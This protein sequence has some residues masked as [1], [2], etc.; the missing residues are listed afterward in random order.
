[1]YTRSKTM[2]REQEHKLTIALQELKTSRELCQ[3]LLQEQEDSEVEV[4]MVVDRNSQLKEQLSELDIQYM[5]VIDQRDRL[6]GIIDTFHECT[7]THE[8][9]LDRIT[10]LESELL[11]SQSLV[12]K[13]KLDMESIQVQ[14]NYNLY[15]ELLCVNSPIVNSMLPSVTPNQISTIDLTCEDSFNNSVSVS[16]TNTSSYRVKPFKSSVLSKK[17]LKKCRKLDKSIKKTQNALKLQKNN[18]NKVL[19]K[20]DHSQLIEELELCTNKLKQSQIMYDTDTQQLYADISR[21]EK[22]LF[23]ANAKYQLVQKENSEHILAA[24]ELVDLCTYNAERYDSLINNHSCDCVC[25]SLKS[26]PESSSSLNSKT[27]NQSTPTKKT[28]VYSDKIGVGV[29]IILS[30]QLE[31]PVFNYCMPGA[32]YQQIVNKILS[33]KFD[34]Q[35]TIVLLIGNSIGVRKKYISNCFET[36][37]NLN[38]FNIIIC[39]FPYSVSLT[40]EANNDIYLLNNYIHTLTCYNNLFSFFDTNNFISG[41]KLTEDTMYLS[42]KSL[43]KIATLVA[44]CINAVICNITKISFNNDST[45]FSST[46]KNIVVT[47]LN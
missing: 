21:L 16:V 18:N 29:G 28:Y 38:V 15:N 36:L 3:R 10:N 42:K 24:T 1:M 5:D 6:Q 13:L 12:D 20:K 34:N 37:S 40:K 31:G 44:Y 43:K 33:T 45:D 27:I 23:D 4:K 22:S 32:T 11:I 19:F 26:K 39:A 41:F 35:S 8:L 47:N 14:N 9:A 30:R 2:A 25:T 46:T 7:K 17:K